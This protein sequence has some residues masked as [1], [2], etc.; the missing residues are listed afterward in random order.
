MRC[1]YCGNT[2]MQAVGGRWEEE[3]MGFKAQL[4]TCEN[5]DCKGY[6]SSYTFKAPES[7]ESDKEPW[8]P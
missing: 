3:V 2:D 7:A 4:A 6:L 5:R 8:T 1:P